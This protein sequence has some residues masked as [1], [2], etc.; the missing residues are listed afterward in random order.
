MSKPLANAYPLMKHNNDTDNC[1]AVG[2]DAGRM[3]KVDAI[4]IPMMIFRINPRFF[5]N[6][7]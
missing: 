6:M 4:T 1:K 2:K 7:S 5:S 3:N